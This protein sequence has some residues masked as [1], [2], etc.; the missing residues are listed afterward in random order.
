MHIND[1]I[2]NS[3]FPEG[4]RREQRSR[5]DAPIPD[6]VITEYC[7]VIRSIACVNYASGTSSHY[8]LLLSSLW[9]IL[10][11]FSVYRDSD[12]TYRFHFPANSDQAVHYCDVG[13]AGTPFAG[14]TCLSHSVI[15]N[16]SQIRLRRPSVCLHMCNCLRVFIVFIVV[17][18]M[19]CSSHQSISSES[20][21]TSCTSLCYSF[22]LQLRTRSLVMYHTHS[23]ISG[24]YGI[25]APHVVETENWN[26][27]HG[28]Q[29]IWT[30]AY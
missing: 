17:P 26:M 28:K 14:I 22:A 11:H 5:R 18:Q 27:S 29:N 16:E 4:R 24:T 13:S 2:N 19:S 10:V 6:V 21:F 8:A 9:L 15:T 7:I 23:S 20:C 30:V 12:S 1:K 3:L 25:D